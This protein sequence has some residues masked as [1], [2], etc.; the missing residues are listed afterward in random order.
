MVDS[1]NIEAKFIVSFIAVVEVME[2]THYRSGWKLKLL[3]RIRNK[4]QRK[5]SVSLVLTLIAVENT[6]VVKEVVIVVDMD[7]DV[8][9]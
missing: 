8:I 7:L 9:K 3:Q 4:I 5:V 6:V 2:E 1:R